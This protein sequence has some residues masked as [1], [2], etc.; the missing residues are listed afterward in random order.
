VQYA[1][2]ELEYRPVE[3]STQVLAFLTEKLP[4]AQTRQSDG[5]MLPLLALLVP[6]RHALQTVLPTA[7]CHVPGVQGVG[8][9]VPTLLQNEPGGQMLGTTV[10]RAAQYVPAG[11]R[12]GA[13]LFAGQYAAAGQFIAAESPGQ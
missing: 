7:D 6:S 9:L 10:F 1:A 5:A 12:I 2:P 8:V 11:Q 3:H 4:G 13:L